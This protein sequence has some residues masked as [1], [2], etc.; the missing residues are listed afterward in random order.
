M[1]WVIRMKKKILVLIFA[2]AL[3][4]IVDPVIADTYNNYDKNGLVSCGGGLVDNIPSLIPKVI[5]IVYTII[6]I[7]VPIV[8]VIIGSL[9][10]LKGV[11]AQKEDD[12]KKGRQ[13]FI[14]RLIAAALVFFVFVIVKLV[15]SFV[16]D[17]SNLSIMEC[18]QC[19]I[20]NECN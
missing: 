1:L 12:I 18:A 15:I 5:S 6:Q 11:I 9:D 17:S 10:L 20:E 16:A 19:F 8:L 3:L 7:A 2:I 4:I 14:K 13:M